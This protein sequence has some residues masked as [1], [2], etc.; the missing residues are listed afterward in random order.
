[1]LSARHE[2]SN[3]VKGAGE[4]RTE[5]STA[6]SIRFRGNE[7][8]PELRDFAASAVQRAIRRFERRVADVTIMLQD[9]NGPRGGVDKRVKIS[10][11]VTGRGLMTVRATSD[12]EYAAIAAACFRGRRKLVRAVSE[13][14]SSRALTSVVRRQWPVTF[15]PHSA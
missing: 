3:D 2:T 1:V 7:W 13:F 6:R 15:A 8:T 11:N 4:M 12:N 10:F 5:F 9:L 14:R